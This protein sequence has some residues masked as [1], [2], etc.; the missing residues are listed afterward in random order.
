MIVDELA[1]GAAE[2]RGACDARHRVHRAAIGEG[3]YRTAIQVHGHTILSAHHEIARGQRDIDVP[4]KSV[5][6]RTLRE[7]RDPRRADGAD[8]AA[9][10][11]IDGTRGARA[12]RTAREAAVHETAAARDTLGEHRGGSVATHEHAAVLR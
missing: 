8:V 1:A 7:Q 4:A 6:A 2:D 12:T 11:Q 3:I 10:R 5:R 9:E